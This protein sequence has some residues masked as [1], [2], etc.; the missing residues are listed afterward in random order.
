MQKWLPR[1]LNKYVTAYIWQ[2]LY[3]KNF[4]TLGVPSYKL[5]IFILFRTPRLVQGAALTGGWGGFRM[6]TGTPT[7]LER[8]KK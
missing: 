6:L 2:Y 4:A 5:K 1:Y 7:A 3:L 8:N